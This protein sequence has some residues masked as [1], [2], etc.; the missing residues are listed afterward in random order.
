MSRASAGMKE[1]AE[2]HRRRAS[3]FFLYRDRP[4]DQNVEAGRGETPPKADN[5][6]GDS[7]KERSS[8]VLY[9]ETRASGYNEDGSSSILTAWP[10]G[11]SR[12]DTEVGDDKR[13][14]R[15][16]EE[17]EEGEEGASGERGAKRIAEGARTCGEARSKEMSA[18]NYWDH[19]SAGSLASLLPL[20]PLLHSFS[21]PLS[22]SVSLLIYVPPF[23]RYPTFSRGEEPR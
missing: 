18:N 20:P 23:C 17:G 21:L 14:N 8:I 19:P 15:E 6:P 11:K 3:S 9:R 1:T 13:K 5:F 12:N 16:E 22:L 7:E 10:H 2:K 4:V